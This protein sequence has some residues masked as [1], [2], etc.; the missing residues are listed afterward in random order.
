MLRNWVRQTER[1][2]GL[3]S[4]PTGEQSEQI[5]ALELE[6][7]KLRQPRIRRKE[8]ASHPPR[9][10]AALQVRLFRRG[11]RPPVYAMKGSVDDRRDL[12]GVE[13]ILGS[14]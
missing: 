3:R 10:P 1:N 8:S 9:E 2:D 4:G 14:G 12:Y 5:K 6:V 7:R 11:A 13:P